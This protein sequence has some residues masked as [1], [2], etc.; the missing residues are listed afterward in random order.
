MK[1][2]IFA[3]GKGE[4]MRPLTDHTPKPLL[5]AGGKRLIEW[6]LERLARLGVRDIV[7]NTS[8]LAAAFPAALGDGSRWNVALH[9]SE[10]GAEPLETGGGMLKARDLLGTQPFLALNGDVYCDFDL[11][12]LGLR[13]GDLANLVLV[14]N[15]AHHPRGDFRLVNDRLASIDS[16]GTAAR[17]TFAGIGIYDP[18][19]LDDWRRVVGDDAGANETP[20]RFKLAPLLHA[21]IAKGRVGGM[22]HRGC[23]TDVG[24]PQRLA[25]LDT[26]LG[27]GPDHRTAPGRANH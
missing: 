9:Y 14:D 18:T 11:A 17:L 24:T 8:W 12:T 6:H 1:A 2:L 27:S 26:V 3:A 5:Q 23:W 21:A 25:Q 10:E 13:D 20:P 4:R 16:A 7:I 19:L 15:P 22:H